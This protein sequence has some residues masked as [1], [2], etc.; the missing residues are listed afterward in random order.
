MT[1]S[2]NEI[3]SY[4]GLLITLTASLVFLAWQLGSY[5]LLG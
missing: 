2:R 5:G 1:H 3:V 4:A